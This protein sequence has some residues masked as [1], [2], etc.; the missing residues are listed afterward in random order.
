MLLV[1]VILFIQ[2]HNFVTKPEQ[3]EAWSLELVVATLHSE[4]TKPNSSHP[5][6]LPSLLAKTTQ[7][8]NPLTN[9][10]W[11]LFCPPTRS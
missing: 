9:Q 5:A 10:S 2:K 1:L 4:A 11:T 6:R 7:S 3:R 8:T